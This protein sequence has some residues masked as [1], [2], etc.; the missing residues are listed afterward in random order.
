MRAR[1]ADLDKCHDDGVALL[2]GLSLSASGGTILDT[3]AKLEE[4]LITAIEELHNAVGALDS[5]F[6]EAPLS[7]LDV[8]TGSSPQSEHPSP[9][10]IRDAA[11]RLKAAYE[12]EA[13]EK[14]LI[15]K[16]TRLNTP[17]TTVSAYLQ[18]WSARAAIEGWRESE[19]KA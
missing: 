9:L 14:Q 5:I 17:Q 6:E 1:A 8:L 7:A 16:D 10:A 13:F 19:G 12:E 11:H 3:Q 4:R 18:V 15:L 2:T